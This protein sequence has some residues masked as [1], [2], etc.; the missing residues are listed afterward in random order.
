VGGGGGGTCIYS[1]R[2]SEV[3]SGIV[4]VWLCAIV[5]W[6]CVCGCVC[7]VRKE[8]EWRENGFGEGGLPGEASVAA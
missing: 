1:K 4:C 7:V 5:S 2:K 8:E 3:W 6:V